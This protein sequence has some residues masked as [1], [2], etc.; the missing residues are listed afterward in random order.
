V[1]LKPPPLRSL[2]LRGLRAAP[3]QVF[4]G[5]RLTPLI[6]DAPRDDLRIARR[7]YQD[8][9]SVVELGGGLAYAST[10]VPH[11]LVIEWTGDGS[12]VGAFGTALARASDAKRL[13]GLCRGVQLLHRMAKREEGNRL[14]LLPQHLAFEGFLAICFGGPE[15]AWTEYSRRAISRGLDPRW[16]ASWSGHAVPGLEDALRVFEI[17]EGQCGA[18]LFLGDV[19]ASVFVVSHPD[20]YRDLHGT[21]IEDAYAEELL[22]A[23]RWHGPS[24]ELPPLIEAARAASLDDL[25]EALRRARQEAAAFHLDLAAGLIQRPLVA[26]RVYR[27]G[28]F[29]LQRF[30][31]DLAL[32]EENHIG[33]AIVRDGGVVEYARTYRLS[34]AQARRAYLLRQLS[35]YGW[36]IDATARALVVTRDELLLRL[37]NAGFGYLILEHVLKAAQKRA[38]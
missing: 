28:P 10:Y 11:A 22:Q 25:R 14:R 13:S 35:A 17:H 26:E 19:L 5:V 34:A 30:S 21:L 1:K 3:S 2:A 27:A 20:D 15:I 38:R 32:H 33:E 8:T 37:D 16:E 12:P 31:T 24:P 6:R 23:A 18:L 9:M 7:K 29:W 4:G 36:N